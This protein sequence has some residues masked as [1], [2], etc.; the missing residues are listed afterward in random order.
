MCCSYRRCCLGFKLQETLLT[1]NNSLSCYP[2]VLLWPFF[3][4]DNGRGR[5]LIS[6]SILK[7]VLQGISVTSEFSMWSQCFLAH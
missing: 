4:Q 2:I 1:V 3:E 7:V 5:F 6:C